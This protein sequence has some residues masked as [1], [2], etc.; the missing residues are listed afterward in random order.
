LN[1]GLSLYGFRYSFPIK[2]LDCFE[3]TEGKIAA[4]ACAIAQ[5]LLSIG[6]FFWGKKKDKKAGISK[7]EMMGVYAELSNQK[8]SIVKMQKG[9]N[10]SKVKEVSANG[11]IIVVGLFGKKS[12]LE[13]SSKSIK[14]AE[15]MRMVLRNPGD[16]EVIDVTVPLQYY[17]S[18]S[19]LKLNGLM[20]R[21]ML[22]FCNPIMK[23]AEMPWLLVHYYLK[24]KEGSIFVKEEDIVYIQ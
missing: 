16:L 5:L 6:A 23:S 20:K 10:E 19:K 9:A 2:I 8:S 4:A 17:T 13:K 12:S 11:L 21:D 22:G 14:D 24:G 18:K 3:T 7:M 15:A 1:L